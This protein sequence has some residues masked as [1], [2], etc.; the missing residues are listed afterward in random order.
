MF[1]CFDSRADPEYTHAIRQSRVSIM[2]TVI[3]LFYALVASFL[4]H[5]EEPN[6][7]RL[8]ADARQALLDKQISLPG[9]VRA[10]VHRQYKYIFVEFHDA[11]E[12]AILAR[13]YFD[14]QGNRYPL[15]DEAITNQRE[16]VPPIV[17]TG[18]LSK[19]SK[20]T[21]WDKVQDLASKE[22]PDNFLLFHV[23]S[24]F[25]MRYP[26]DPR[27]WEAE[28]H[29]FQYTPFMDEVLLKRFFSEIE[30]APDAS[31]GLKK[32]VAEWAV[33]F[34]MT[35]EQHAAMQSKMEAER[36]KKRSEELAPTTRAKV[37]ENAPDFAGET[38]S[39]E[40]VSLSGEKG[41]VVLVNF[42][43]TWCWPCVKEMPHL[44][45]EV[46]QKYKDRK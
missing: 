42:F 11:N 27:R 23:T 4:L 6:R 44:E 15:I 43:A 7:D 14:T 29:W 41:K 46:F 12:P 24:E 30:A 39:G 3:V 34:S 32:T 38:L 19:L 5:A 17:Q 37:G 9:D 45:K 28:Y 8:I 25:L 16:S 33:V 22:V 10:E 26:D 13:L 36:V 35:P 40:K 31:A 18:D 20:E 2:K 1:P 21:L